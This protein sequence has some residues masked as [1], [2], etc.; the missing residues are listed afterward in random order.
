VLLIVD[1]AIVS[2]LDPFNWEV[3]F[4]VGGW[5]LPAARTG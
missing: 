1:V 4:R 3:F 5:A 2:R